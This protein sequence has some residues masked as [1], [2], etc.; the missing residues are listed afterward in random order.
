M[1]NLAVVNE[2]TKISDAA[3]EAML[4]AFETQWNRDLASVWRVANSAF[5]FVPCVPKARLTS[6]GRF[7]QESCRLIW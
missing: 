7:H 4:P 2:S 6:G 1:I 5:S 3:V